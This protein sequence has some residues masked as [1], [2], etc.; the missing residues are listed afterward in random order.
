MSSVQPC[1]RRVF[2]CGRRVNRTVQH[3]L[4]QSCLGVHVR[5]DT[6]YR[7]QNLL[8][9]IKRKSKL[10][11]CASSEKSWCTV[12]TYFC[13]KWFILF[14]FFSLGNSHH[15]S[16]ALPASHIPT[17]NFLCFTN[18]TAQ[19]LQ[20]LQTHTRL[21]ARNHYV[22]VCVCVCVCDSQASKRKSDS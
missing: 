16:P 20:F 10:Q 6:T 1:R 5:P 3:Q 19:E 17:C 21:W 12:I 11:K 9:G 8:G 15:Q 22:R 7:F 2:L 13:L 18:S 14:F 4:L